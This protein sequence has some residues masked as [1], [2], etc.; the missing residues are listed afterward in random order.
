[1]IP[2]IAFPF[3]ALFYYTFSSW[4]GKDKKIVKSGVDSTKMFGQINTDMPG[5]SNEVAKAGISDKYK[6]YLQAYKNAKDQSALNGIENKSELQK[7]TDNPLQY[8]SAYSE[9]DIKNM[10]AQKSL[11]SLKKLMDNSK[12][13][14]NRR[15]SSIKN[16]SAN[17]SNNYSYNAGR[18][19]TPEEMIAS[20][21][22]NNNTQY[23]SNGSVN[24]GYSPSGDGGR[25]SGDGGNMRQFKEQ[26]NYIDSLQ[27]ARQAAY[28]ETKENAQPAKHNA[29]N[30]DPSKDSSFKPLPVSFAHSTN[31]AFNTARFASPDLNIKAIIDE[32][33]KAFAGT[34]VRI[35]LLDEIV[36]GNNIIP[37]GTYIYGQ[38]S[39]FQT[40]RVNISV[41]QI[42]YNNETL[43]VKLDVFDN[44]GYLGLYVPGSNFREFSKEI[45][46]QG[47][48]GLSSI[49]TSTGSTDVTTGILM[50]LF[51]TTTSSAGKLIKQDKVFL[52]YNHII[53]LK[54]PNP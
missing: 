25:G 16:N 26:M 52:K 11:D 36:V 47:T 34:R 18:Q 39:G 23:H 48:N 40:Q 30:F 22:K 32:D 15:M 42:L 8:Q 37:K 43:P 6:A 1:V 19:P 12:A 51:Q 46:T 21:N 49:Q 31:S 50:K 44:D 5:V 27:R 9:E 38:I 41:T 10:Q 7:E 45:G 54:S 24:G 33:E 17:N 28:S 3:I 2:L 29:Y 35:R 53:F 20:L 13:E 14:M 4:K